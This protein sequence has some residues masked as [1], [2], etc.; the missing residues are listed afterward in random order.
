MVSELFIGFLSSVGQPAAS[1]TI[2][3]NT[4]EEV[5]W[6]N[7]RSPWRR[8][9]TWLLI[10]V[11]LQLTLDRT[12]YKEAMLFLMSYILRQALK[13]SLPSEIIY[14]MNAKLARRLLK[15]GLHIDDVD[16]NAL[17]YI[18]EIMREA[19]DTVSKRWSSIQQEHSTTLNLARLA[20]LDFDN[21]SRVSLPALDN[22]INS[23]SSRQTKSKARVFIP[24]SGLMKYVS[25]SA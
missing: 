11:V 7:T 25:T 16:D 12:S 10:R 24:T 23:I 22:Y 3:K 1:P 20:D 4:R 5:F 9:A 15:L 14:S 6:N 21:D 2:S 17:R 13:Q 8:P 19:N 18:Q